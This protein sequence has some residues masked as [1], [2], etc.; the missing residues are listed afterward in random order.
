MSLIIKCLICF[1]ICL[2]I[3]VYFIYLFI[4]F[5]IIFMYISF[6]QFQSRI[7][8]THSYCCS[9]MGYCFHFDL[10]EGKQE[11]PSAV[12][13]LRASVILKNISKVSNPSDHIFLLIFFFTSFE[14]MKKLTELKPHFCC[15]RA[16]LG[17]EERLGA[18]L[19][20]ICGHH[21]NT[22]SWLGAEIL[23]SSLQTFLKT[24]LRV[25]HSYCTFIWNY[26]ATY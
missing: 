17:F 5:Y 23:L 16:G 19:G 26:L 11:Q 6:M 21:K 25:K 14:L 3:F 1:I 12:T 8:H 22:F 4:Y 7:M 10:Y 20:P 18:V 15:S 24:L 9:S 2:F 13:G